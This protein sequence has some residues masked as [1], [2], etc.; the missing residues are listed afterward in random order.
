MSAVRPTVRP[1]IEGGVCVEV[2]CRLPT[3]RHYGLH[4]AGRSLELGGE[5]R[6]LVRS[7]LRSA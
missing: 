7:L 5:V 4:A 6:L 1:L 3:R 2:V